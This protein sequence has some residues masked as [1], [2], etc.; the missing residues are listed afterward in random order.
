MTKF[1][2]GEFTP[3]NPEKYVG[4]YPIVYR[5]SW[6]Y[7]F[8][9]RCDEHPDILQ[10]S[11]ESVEVPYIHP[12]DGKVHTYFP[13]FVVKY[14]DMNG[15]QHIEMIEIKPISQS[16]EESAKT[17]KDLEAIMIN[18]AK[19]EYATKFCENLG[20]KFRIATEKQLFR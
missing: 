18:K 20:I 6:E 14:I 16:M 8:M 19:W 13:D 4:K 11:S 2:Q 9:M 5:S 3:D 7:R 12:G 10:W 17:R 1:S 15:V